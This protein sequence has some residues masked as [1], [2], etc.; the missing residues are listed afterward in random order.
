MVGT[1]AGINVAER[2]GFQGSDSGS[3]WAKFLVGGRYGANG[4]G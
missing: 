2:G 1:G 4:G 3:S